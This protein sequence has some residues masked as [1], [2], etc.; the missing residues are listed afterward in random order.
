MAKGLNATSV[1]GSDK[2]CGFGA[3]GGLDRLPK[4]HVK[5][6]TSRKRRAAQLI[7]SLPAQNG[8]LSAI[9]RRI[10]L[11]PTWRR[12]TISSLASRWLSGSCVR[13]MN[14]GSHRNM[15]VSKAPAAT[16]K[17]LKERGSSPRRI[18]RRQQQGLVAASHSSTEALAR[19]HVCPWCCHDHSKTYTSRVQEFRI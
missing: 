2:L 16:T 4:K 10:L 5:L 3:A 17:R 15:A 1:A 6:K 18:Y 12:P 19:V 11:S 13:D 7:T 8:T 9:I 14:N